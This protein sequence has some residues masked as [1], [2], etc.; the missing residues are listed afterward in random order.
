MLRSAASGITRVIRRLN[1]GRAM[2]LCCS[3]KTVSS[4]TSISSASRHDP[5]PG[6]SRDLGT[7]KLPIKP[8]AY[9]NV[10]GKRRTLRRH[11]QKSRFALVSV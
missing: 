1:P 9:R 6:E 2:M 7:P 8:I 5:V 11:K 3:A 10:T 4:P